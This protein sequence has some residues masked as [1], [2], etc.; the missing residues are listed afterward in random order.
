MEPLCQSPEDGVDLDV[1]LYRD[2]SK[3]QYTCVSGALLRFG[4]SVLKRVSDAICA[5]RMTAVCI[6][7]MV[8]PR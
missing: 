5:N 6:E 2:G 7:R 3:E 4:E 1:T 8:D